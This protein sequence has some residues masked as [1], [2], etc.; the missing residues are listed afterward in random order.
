MTDKLTYK[1]KS[2][3]V[4]QTIQIYQVRN[5]DTFYLLVILKEIYI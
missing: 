5:P 1:K 4:Q 3:I 2:G